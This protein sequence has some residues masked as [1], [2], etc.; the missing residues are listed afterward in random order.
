MQRPGRAA[1]GRV[2]LRAELAEH[3][4][5]RVFAFA[6]ELDVLAV[7]DAMRLA[8][9]LAGEARLQRALLERPLDVTLGVGAIVVA[10]ASVAA[11]RHAHRGSFERVDGGS[12]LGPSRRYAGDERG[13][14]EGEYTNGPGP[15][16]HGHSQSSMSAAA[17]AWGSMLG[18]AGYRC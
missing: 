10:A 9:R 5:D 3:R 6:L 17:P 14:G 12:L 13:E 2:D 7:G 8:G 11:G 15:G 4:P 16:E 18:R 1:V